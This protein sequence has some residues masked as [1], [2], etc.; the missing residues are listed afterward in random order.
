MNTPIYAPKGGAGFPIN[1]SIKYSCSTVT[2]VEQ[3]FD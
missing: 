3:Q 2:D 1:E